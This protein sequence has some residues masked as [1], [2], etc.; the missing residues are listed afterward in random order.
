MGQTPS[1]L[2]A[3]GGI[4]GLS[5]ALCL[6]RAGFPVTLVEQA[7][8][9]REVGAGIQ[10]S[11]NASRILQKLELDGLGDFAVEPGSIRIH[12]GPSGNRLLTLPLKPEMKARHGAPYLTLSRAE[13]HQAL[14]RKASDEALIDIHLGHRAETA[15]ILDD[16]AELEAGGRQFSADILIAADGVWSPLRQ[17][18]LGDQPPQYTGHTAWRALIDPAD[19]PA[20]LSGAH[21][22]LW[23]GP[24]SHLVHYPVCGGDKINVVALTE[25][26]WREEGWNH[27]GRSEELQRA[28]AR[29]ASPA[30]HVI[31][32]M[33]EPLK[34]ALCGRQPDLDWHGHGCFTLLGDAAHPMLPYLAQGAAMAIEDAHVLARTLQSNPE[35][36]AA[37][38][39]YEAAR[40]PRTGRVQ[41]GAFANAATFHLS[42]P[43]ALARNMALRA[44]GGAPKLFLR[45]YDWLYGHDVTV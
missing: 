6:A 27:Q 37:L 2:I 25:S 4:G 32:A 11:P 45:R 21:T 18:L 20:G 34:W 28:F 10:L 30:R 16:H 12:D 26:S 29:W 3:G 19:M 22:H 13:L 43:A 31:K 35:P 36:M 44:A 1:I 17:A 38:R 14:S 8:T 40:A 9:F 24:D 42:G 7:D 5:A 41:Q 33:G 39:A 23:L 15:R